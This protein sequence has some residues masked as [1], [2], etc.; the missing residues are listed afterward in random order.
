MGIE[1]DRGFAPAEKPTQQ[2]DLQ[3]EW[4]DQ[5]PQQTE[6]QKLPRE[7]RS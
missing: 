6:E 1:E 2:R 5:K 7:N 3:I 4:M